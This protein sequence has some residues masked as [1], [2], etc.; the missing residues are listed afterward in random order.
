M[1]REE[2]RSAISSLLKEQGKINTG[3]TIAFRNKVVG[4]GSYKGE[5]GDWLKFQWWRCVLEVKEA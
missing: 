1:R 3:S 2:E 4:E 5:V